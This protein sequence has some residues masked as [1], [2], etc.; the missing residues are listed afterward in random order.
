MKNT[1]T[2]HEAIVIALINM[3]KKTFS[4]TFDE[5]ATY[6]EKRFIP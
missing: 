1:L 4:A 5:I 6:I 3:N 2:R